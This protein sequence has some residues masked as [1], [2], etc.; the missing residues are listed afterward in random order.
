MFAGKNTMIRDEGIGDRRSELDTVIEEYRSETL[1]ELPDARIEEDF[2]ELQRGVEALEIERLR[3]LAEIDR[4][5]LFARD[6]F[7]S[8]LA[9]LG[10][11]HDVAWGPAKDGVRTARALEAMP[12]TRRALN[13]AEVSLSAARLWSRP[14]RPTR[15][16]L[17][18]RRRC[19]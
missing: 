2:A 14:A 17:T 15:R 4:R 18:S 12:A 9:W 16:R 1:P 10:S 7:L 19:S 3:R 8:A 6:G 13:E 5:G 11:R